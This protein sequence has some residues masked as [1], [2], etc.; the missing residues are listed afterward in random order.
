M[1]INVDL[2]LCEGFAS[3]MR[4]CPEVF[5]VDD[6][7]VVHIQVDVVP[8]ELEEK[9]QMAAKRCPRQAISISD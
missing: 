7:D 6:Q 5:Q 8:P 1:K 4:L 3:C 2:E 9:V